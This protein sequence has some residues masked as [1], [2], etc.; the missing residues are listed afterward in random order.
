MEE[1][2]LELLSDENYKERKID[3][4]A[5]YFQKTQTQD[6][7]QF[8][9]FINE[10][11]DKGKLVRSKHNDYYLPYQ[12]DYYTGVVEL[13]K[14]GFAFVKV[15][16]ER[17]FYIHETRLKDAYDKDIVLLQ[18]I[19]SRGQRE[20]GEV[21][22]VL[23]RGKTR[24]VGEVRKGKKDFYVQVDDGKF[25]K[26]IFVDG[27][28]THGAMPGHKVVVEIK[29]F[30][31]Q[32]KG[33]IVKIIGHVNDPGMDI[34]SIVHE[35]DVDIEFPKDIYQSLENIPQDLDPSDINN[36]IDLRN[37]LIVTIDGDDAKDLDDAISLKKL[38]NGHYQLGVHI[39][40]VSYYVEEGSPLD[41]EAIKR[42]TSIY[43]VDRVI[44]MLPHQLSNGICSLNPN[45][46]RYTISCIM[47]IDSLGNV[48]QHDI[49]PTVIHSSYRMTYN[50]V[51]KILAGDSALQQQYKDAV[52]L[53][54][55]MQELA[56]I[57]RQKKKERGAIDFDVNEAKVIVDKQGNPLD[58]VLRER[59]ASDKIIEEFML[60]A[61]ETVAQHFKWM[62]LPFIYRVHE[63]PKL[64]KLQQFMTMVKPLGY[65]I[66][67]SLENVY[68]QELRKIVEQSQGTQEQT[69]ISTLLLRCMQKARYDGE[70]LGHF[71]LADDYYTHFTSPIRRYPDLLVHRLIRHY[72]FQQKYDQVEHFQQVI[73]VLAEQSSIRER[74][75]IDIEREVM[76]MKMAEYMSKHIGEEFEGVISSITSFGFFVELENTIDGLVHISDLTDDYYHYDDQSMR[77]IGERSGK[78]FQ[79][80]D[81]VKIRVASSSK[82]EKTIDFE[83]VGQKSRKRKQKTIHINDKKVKTNARKKGKINKVGKRRARR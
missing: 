48:V 55:L 28:H 46:D 25:V 58:V 9:K 23:E 38:D 63:H 6:Y 50:N 32:I 43:L 57:L 67:G 12:L 2:I 62:D 14:K 59:G 11:E 68:P 8:I 41:Q 54:F 4:L 21:K 81:K 39:A 49:L 83:L 45:V 3:E 1:K 77:L 7:I 74:E 65:T 40:D 13:N 69:V 76:D 42:G 72:L 19:P 61:N 30:K 22:R 34:L 64:K 79:L 52:P 10:L 51:N 73:P 24:Y 26:P 56:D 44:P 17:E 20:E 71:G 82:K 37:E 47:E 60:K 29:T 35:H 70:C 27:A 36:R 33:D 16:E 66:K 80:S 5:R 53:F 78:V 31:P 75:A 15:D 18:K